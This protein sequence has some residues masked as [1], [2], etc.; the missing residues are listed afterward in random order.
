MFKQTSVNGLII[1]G[2]ILCG[3]MLVCIWY[4]MMIGLEG[5]GLGSIALPFLLAIVFAGLVIFSFVQAFIKSNLKVRI[6]IPFN[7][8]QFS[9]DAVAPKVKRQKD[10]NPGTVVSRMAAPKGSNAQPAAQRP[11]TTAPVRNS[12]GRKGV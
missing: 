7:L 6:N 2:L 3:P 9:G 12:F 4:T 11:M 10:S 8:K 1:T 5:G